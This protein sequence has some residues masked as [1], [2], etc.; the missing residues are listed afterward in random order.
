MDV[1]SRCTR[2]SPQARYP[3][4]ADRPSQTGYGAAFAIGAPGPHRLHDESASPSPLWFA[5]TLRVLWPSRG[6]APTTASGG[7]TAREVR[8][9]RPARNFPTGI[10]LTPL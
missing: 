9:P 10:R 7:R 4:T 5:P 1:T 2:P 8:R 6:T 3:P